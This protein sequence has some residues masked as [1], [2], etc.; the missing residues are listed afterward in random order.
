[1]YNFTTVEKDIANYWQG[2]HTFRLS[3][4][5]RQGKQFV[6]YDGPPFATGTPH[7]GHLL[8]GTIKDAVARYKNMSGYCVPRQWGWD[9]H[10]VPV[11]TLV[12]NKIGLTRVDALQNDKV[13]E[14]NEECRNSV[15]LCADQ[16]KEIV[17]R[18][19][20]WV[21]FDHS[22]KTMDKN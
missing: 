13:H 16:W 17:S 1:M 7:Y 9:C 12:Q 21:D 10:G 20:R 3:N 2:F 14:F 22:Y 4:D 6:F 5:R 18:M 11:E 19:G 15:L 8:V